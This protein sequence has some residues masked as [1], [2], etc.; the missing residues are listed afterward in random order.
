MKIPAIIP[1]YN[2]RDNIGG[3]SKIYPRSSI[4]LERGVLSNKPYPYVSVIIVNYNGRGYLRDCLCSSFLQDGVN[5]DIIVVDNASIDGSVE[6]VKKDFPGARLI[7]N[8]ENL[9]YAAAVNQGILASES[10]FVICLNNDAILEKNYIFGCLKVMA[11]LP[12]V[13]MCCGKIM[14]MDKKTI[15]STGQFL[16]RS[17]KPCERGYGETDKGQYDTAG[18]VFG[19]CGAVALYRRSM[20]EDVK[21]PLQA[22]GSAYF[23]E[24][25]GMFYED[26]DLAWRA[27]KKGWRAYYTPDAVAY[28]ARGASCRAK[29]AEFP[30]LY[31]FTRL[32][33]HLQSHLIKNRYMTIIKNDSWPGFLANFIFI[34]A[35]ECKIMF[36]AAFFRPFLFADLFRNLRFLRKAFKSKLCGIFR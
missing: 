22:G 28:H 27:Q 14:R 7:M 25:Y 12:D 17:R 13:G 33:A 16:A 2:G 31:G 26:L 8:R 29:D 5:S 18:Y 23:D 15:D 19:P 6:M 30:Y 11:G 36:Y 9:L 34:I 1:A 20:L 21:M 3:K 24:D 4:L 35:Y 32:P 10:E